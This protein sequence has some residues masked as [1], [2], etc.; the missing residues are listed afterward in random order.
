[1]IF[2]PNTGNYVNAITGCAGSGTTAD[3]ARAALDIR[4]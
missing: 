2:E 1:M 3:N 4:P